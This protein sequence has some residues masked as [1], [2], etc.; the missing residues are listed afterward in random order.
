[1]TDVPHGTQ[2]RS[3]GDVFIED[4]QPATYQPDAARALLEE[5][6]YAGEP[7]SYRYL[8]DYY[9]GETDTAQILGQM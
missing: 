8:R 4:H 1:M 5:V 9:T 7:I 2:M 3:F 6:S